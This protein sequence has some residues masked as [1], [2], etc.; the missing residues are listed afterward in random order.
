MSTPQSFPARTY[1]WERP[2][3]SDNSVPERV[4]AFR[5]SNSRPRQNIRTPTPDPAPAR[6]RPFP[7]VQD[8]V[9]DITISMRND[10]FKWWNA[11]PKTDA[12]TKAEEA[13]SGEFELHVPSVEGLNIDAPFLSPT[14]DGLRSFRNHPHPWA[15]NN[16]QNDAMN[17][18]DQ[19][20]KQFNGRPAEP[21]QPYES[22]YLDHNTQ[23]AIPAALQPHQA[24]IDGE[25]FL[26]DLR[27]WIGNW[28]GYLV[29]LLMFLF[30]G[31]NPIIKP[32]FK[33]L[34]RDSVAFML[35]FFSFLFYL[36]R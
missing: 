16:A 24:S 27:D 30:F 7:L 26:Q 18:R 36:I 9:P 2:R 6:T 10:K 12:G 20:F 1:P 32:V 28:I 8:E 4:D 14:R 25:G 3:V 23:G 13:R 33:F 31:M 5:R 22:Q 19:K 17:M 35:L 11:P 21:A 29:I 15:Q 34:L